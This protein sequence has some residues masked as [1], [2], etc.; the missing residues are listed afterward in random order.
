M[1][2]FEILTLVVSCLAVI[3]SVH[4]LREQ[5]KLQREAN[6]LQ[7]VTAELAKRQIEQLQAQEAARNRTSLAVD[8]YKQGNS[9]RLRV[10][11]V[12]NADALDIRIELEVPQGSESPLVK[13]ELAQKFPVKRLSVGGTV[14]L[15][16]GIYLDSPPSIE[17]VVSWSNP[18]G[19]AAREEFTAYVP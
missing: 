19:T 6:E 4:T 2:Q 10:S 12:G 7:R 11:N 3:L 5:R 14:F 13:E 16:C 9:H 1:S 8:L 17:G 15:L 18:D